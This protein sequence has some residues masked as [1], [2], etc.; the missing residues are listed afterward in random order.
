M[1]ARTLRYGDEARQSLQNELE[2]LGDAVKATLGPHGRNV[3]AIT[4]KQADGRQPAVPV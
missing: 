2:V 1:T 3:A 4:E